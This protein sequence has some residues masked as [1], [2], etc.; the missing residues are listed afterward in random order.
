MIHC[1]QKALFE[2]M[3]CKYEGSGFKYNFDKKSW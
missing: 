1:L 2:E 3:F